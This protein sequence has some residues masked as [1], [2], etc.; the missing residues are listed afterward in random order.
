MRRDSGFTLIEVIVSVAILA[1]IS[2]VVWQASGSNMRAKERSEKR[3]EVFQ[4]VAMVMD[5]MSEDLMEAFLYSPTSE[6]LGKSINGEILAKTAFVGK[7]NGDADEISFTSFSHVR[8]LKDV[9]ESDQEEVTYKL[10][11]SKDDESNSLEIVKRSSSPLDANPTE[12]GKTY[13]LL[14]GVKGLSF[15]YYDP[16]KQEWFEEW[17]SEGSDNPSKLPRAVEITL[18]VENP[19]EEGEPIVFTT[20]AIVEMAPGPN[21]F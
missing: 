20:I 18:T 11:P 17:D 1:L 12:G 7:N 13:P 2:I 6:E 8:Y 5:R 3:D 21:D 16:K 9:K 14:K 10:E 4:S 15:R 19:E